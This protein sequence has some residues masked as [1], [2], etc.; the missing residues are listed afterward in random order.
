M[1]RKPKQKQKK[2]DGENL[3]Y[4]I[5]PL[6]WVVCMAIAAILTIAI[7]KAI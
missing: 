7:M 6:G 2:F 3:N 5:N 4:E 1:F